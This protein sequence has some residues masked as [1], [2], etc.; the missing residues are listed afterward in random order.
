[1]AEVEFRNATLKY[2]TLDRPT[3]DKL[4]LRVEDGEFVCVVGPSGCGKSH[5]DPDARGS[6]GHHRRPRV[7][8]GH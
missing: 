7:H 3:I 1:M 8:R 2:P 6:R 4:N 5:D